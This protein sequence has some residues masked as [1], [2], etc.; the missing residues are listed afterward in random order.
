MSLY[1]DIRSISPDLPTAELLAFLIKEKCPRKTIATASLRAPSIVVLK[2]ISD[3]DP[4]IPVVFCQTGHSFPESETYRE[5]IIELLGLTRTSLSGG[6]ET[7]V[8]PGDHDHYERMWADSAIGSGRTSEIVHLNQ[9]LA[10]YDCWISAVY[11]HERLPEIQQRVD[12]HG[13]L[14]RVDPLV[15][16]SNDEVRTFMREHNLPFHPRAVRR[17]PEPLKEPLDPPPSYNY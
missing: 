11:H 7:E 9:T 13:R 10:P 2:L 8:V 5:R 16:W 4:S 3:I 14:I 1:H 17:A 12:V 6:G 15:R